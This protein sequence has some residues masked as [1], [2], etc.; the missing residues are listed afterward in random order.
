MEGLQKL[1]LVDRL[2]PDLLDGKKIN[3]LR[4]REGDINP[5]YLL[6]YA[7]S[8]PALQALVWVTKV[9]RLPLSEAAPF[10]NM[11]PQELLVSMRKHYPDIRIDDEVMLVH[12]LSPQETQ[13]C[14]IPAKAGI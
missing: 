5:G 6:Y 3:T 12:H 14:V 9:E 4:W 1:E 11:T 2:F 8:N 7:S 13:E 10:Y